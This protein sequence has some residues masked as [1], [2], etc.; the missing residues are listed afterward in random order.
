MSAIARSVPRS[1]V[2]ARWATKRTRRATYGPKVAEVAEALGIELLPWQR[3]V[4]D[5]ALEHVRGRLAYRDAVVSVPRQSG[6]STL[7]LVVI[8]HRL[9]ASTCHAVYGAQTR[10]A[11]RQKLLDDFLPLIRRSSLSRLFDVSRATGQEALFALGGT[12]SR[13]RV[14]SSDETAA[15]GQTASLG[16]LDEAWALD[17]AAEQAVR[18]ALVTRRAGQLWIAST[19]GAARSLWWRDKVQTGREAVESGRTEGLAYFEWSAPSPAPISPIRRCFAHSIRRSTE[20]SRSTRSCPISPRCRRQRRRVRTATCRPTSSA[21]AGTSSPRR[22]GNAPRGRSRRD[23]GE[24]VRRAIGASASRC[25]REAIGRICHFCRQADAPRPAARPRPRPRR[26]HLPGR[27]APSSATGAT[28][29]SSPWPSSA[30]AE[31]NRGGGSSSWGTRSLSASRSATDRS[32]TSI[33]CAGRGGDGR[34]V[35]ELAAYLEGTDHAAHG[36][37]H[38]RRPRQGPSARRDARSAVVRRRRWSSRW[39][40]LR[41]DITLAD[42]HVMA[43]AHGDFA[44][45]AEGRQA[46]H[47]AAP[48]ADRRGATRDGSPADRCRG[49]RAPQTG[50]R[51]VSDPSPPSW[52]FGPCCTSCDS[53]P[54]IHV[55]EAT[56]DGRR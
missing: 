29:R 5:V 8:V 3:Q 45:L 6:K 36:P 12:G 42:W 27:G 44:D 13:C 14:I 39:R 55:Y 7:V 33:A 22:T 16:V 30:P 50:R 31:G 11:A 4:A 49:A 28:V 17:Q 19:A 38:G 48:G 40:Q 23:R 43:A 2:P 20:R 41:V 47:R 26:P 25:G 9:L 37:R 52:P 51:H 35:V 53:V 21:A 34:V 18:P 46:G 54:R 56:E 32:H 10:L 15:H 24:V 1:G